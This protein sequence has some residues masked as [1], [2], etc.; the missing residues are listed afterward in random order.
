MNNLRPQNLSGVLG[1]K[2]LCDSLKITSY[3]SKIENKALPH[4]LLAGRPGTG[5][6]SIAI[7]LAND[8][9]REIQTANAASIKTIKDILPYLM[10]LKD[11]SVLFIDEIHALP[12]LVEEFLY[13]AM[14][15]RKID[16]VT[17][18]EA[19]TIPL[20][21]F[22]LVG[23]TT[24]AGELSKPLR[25]RFRIYET[26]DPYSDK[27]IFD[28]LCMNIMKIQSPYNFSLRDDGVM[29]LANISRGTPRIANNILLWVRDCAVSYRVRELNLDF[30]KKCVKMKGIDERGLTIEDRQYLECVKNSKKAIGV[31][32]IAATTGLS[33]S[34]IE[35]VI[36]PY[37]LERQLIQR[38]NK[39]R[40]IV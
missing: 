2:R 8:A 38:T 36:E 25:D 13:P 11:L 10:R 4:I 1:Q 28:I 29:F 35:N 5:K 23:A 21:E 33:R 37:L 31:S 7:A 16:I 34:T 20:P 18:G 14:E 6:T 26:L 24:A 32:T 19:L 17:K 40:V 15:D 30:L 9:C 12:T 3:V 22:T 27:D 39:G